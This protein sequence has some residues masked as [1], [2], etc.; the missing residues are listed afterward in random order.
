MKSEVKLRYMDELLRLGGTVSMHIDAQ[1]RENTVLL[2]DCVNDCVL[3][4]FMSSSWGRAS[5]RAE[6]AA[7]RAQRVRQRTRHGARTRRAQG[8]ARQLCSVRQPVA[9]AMPPVLFA[10]RGQTTPRAR[11]SSTVS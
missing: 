1:S 7:C 6:C 8:P 9:R 2:E 4:L 3:H 5:K 11:R 10:S